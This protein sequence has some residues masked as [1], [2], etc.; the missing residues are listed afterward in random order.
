MCH[1]ISSDYT[2]IGAFV[3]YIRSCRIIL[4]YLWPNFWALIIGILNHGDL[5]VAKEISSHLTMTNAHTSTPTSTSLGT[6]LTPFTK[7]SSSTSSS[8]PTGTFTS[9]F[10]DLATDCHIMSRTSGC[11]RKLT[12][13]CSRWS[14]HGTT[15]GRCS[16]CDRQCSSHGAV[17]VCAFVCVCVCV[18][19]CTYVRVCVHVCMSVQV[20]ACVSLQ[21]C[22]CM[23]KKTTCMHGLGV[24]V[25]YFQIS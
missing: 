20:C 14:S 1:H 5:N 16:S 3:S 6:S 21:V 7:P 17:C 24:K 13:W 22:M 10:M 9:T 8:T 2:L 25:M 15:H 19:V 23:L 12:S 11:F 4:A 18:C